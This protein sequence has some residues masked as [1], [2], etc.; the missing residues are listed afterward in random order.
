[1]LKVKVKYYE[2]MLKDNAYK[3]CRSGKIMPQK[4]SLL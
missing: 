2:N 1:M 4:Y 3:F